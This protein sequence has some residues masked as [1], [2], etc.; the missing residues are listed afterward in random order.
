MLAKR[1]DDQSSGRAEKVYRSSRAARSGK[2]K[3]GKQEE[4]GQE[5]VQCVFLPFVR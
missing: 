4:I 3:T 2:V 1:A 5:R